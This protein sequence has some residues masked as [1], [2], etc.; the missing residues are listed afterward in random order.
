MIT[1]MSNVRAAALATAAVLAGPYAMNAIAEPTGQSAQPQSPDSLWSAW[2][3][4]VGI[5]WNRE[6][7]A[8]MGIHSF[9]TSGKL[10]G[11][12][13]REHERFAVRQSGS[14]D[15]RVANGNLQS[16]VGGSVQARG[17]YVLKTAAGDIDLT[18]FRLKT[19]ADNPLVLDL[20]GADGKAWFYVD[21]LMYELV[22]DNKVLA[23]RTMDLRVSP[24]LA[25]RLGHPDMANWA[26]ADM[27]LT[28][29]VLT[30]GSGAVPNGGGVFDWAGTQV[31]G[32]PN[33]TNFQ[34]DLFMKTFSVQFSRCNGCT[35][36]SSTGQVVFTPSSTLQN[37]VNNGTAVATVAGDPLG[38]SSALWTADI[39]WHGKF[40]GTFPPYGNDQHPYLI[41]NIYR[42]SADGSIDQIGRSGVKHAFLTT[43]QGC[44]SGHGTDSHVLG[45][46]CS[47]TYGTGNND[48]SSDLG[49]RSEIIPATNQW[50]R[51][52][53]IYDT[54]CDGAANSSGN[55]QYSQRLIVVES[56]IDPA[57]QTGA[58]YLFESWY[59]AR[60]DINIYNSMATRGIS[61]TRSGT[62]WNVGSGAAYRLGPAIDRWLEGVS[63]GATSASEELASSEGHTK[64]AVKVFDLGGG[65]WRYDYVVMNFDFARP[66]TEG[67]EPNLR[68]V[69]NFG[70]DRFAVPVAAGVN[71]TNITF[72]DG[73]TDSGN[74]WTTSTVGGSLTWS[75]PVNPTPPTNVPAEL[76]PLNW[77]TM[78]R[79]SFVADGGPQQVATSLHVAETGN[80]QSLSADLLGPLNDTIF[81]DGFE[82]P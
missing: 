68:V 46:Q 32:E 28:A 45:R 10:E 50:G 34:A 73:D 41:W 54:N 5:R 6:L 80:P 21:R 9:E 7:A 15:F 26:I 39:P 53:S 52:G 70:F 47:D 33:G 30:Q 11:R 4:E 42:L 29:Q 38:T 56:Q 12:S 79:F 72:S 65:S 31:P 20:V 51:C 55:T 81:V 18:D 75:A 67:S 24:A 2:G 19:R 16:F 78:F 40:S 60:E 58:T 74:D 48:S 82:S 23:V 69:H 63:P 44:A 36:S 8:D 66:F 13:W 3:G 22:D 77:G 59:L 57:V 43:N 1:L 35:G 25:T 61:P 14:L 49:P 64:V 71:L 62:S 17:G 37:N 76:N 27:E